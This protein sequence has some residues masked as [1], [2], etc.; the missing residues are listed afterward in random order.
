MIVNSLLTYGI[1][2]CVFLANICRRTLLRSNMNKASPVYELFYGFEECI[3][4]E[5]IFYTNHREIFAPGYGPAC[6]SSRLFYKI[7]IQTLTKIMKTVSYTNFKLT[8]FEII[9]HKLCMEVQDQ[10]GNFYAPLERD[11]L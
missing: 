6:A 11:L 5:K 2:Q 9:F 1:S 3:L 4:F 8:N 7:R 10:N